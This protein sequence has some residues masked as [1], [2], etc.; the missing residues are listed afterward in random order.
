MWLCSERSEKHTASMIV[1]FKSL[2][3]TSE[4]RLNNYVKAN[5]KKKKWKSLIRIRKHTNSIFLRDEERQLERWHCDRSA[6]NVAQMPPT[7]FSSYSYE[8]TII[9]IQIKSNISE[10]QRSA[11]AKCFID[12]GH[13]QWCT[14]RNSFDQPRTCTIVQQLMFVCFKSIHEIKNGISNWTT[15]VLCWTARHC[16]KQRLIVRR[17]AN[18]QQQL[19]QWKKFSQLSVVV[20]DE[21]RIWETCSKSAGASDVGTSGINRTNSPRAASN[22]SHQTSRHLSSIIDRVID[23]L[24]PEQ[25]RYGRRSCWASSTLPSCLLSPT[26]RFVIHISLNDKHVIFAIKVPAMFVF[27]LAARDNVP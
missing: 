11:N 14:R 4:G 27:S 17:N 20:S 3:T 24:L 5:R 18:N 19:S 22:Y 25:D 12:S 15:Y 23:W 9:R 26:I 13:S 8:I 2:L 7:H 6:A 1:E 16:R 21:S 10:V